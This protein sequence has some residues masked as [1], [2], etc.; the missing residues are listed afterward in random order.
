[1]SVTER[2]KIIG[3]SHIASSS[4]DEIKQTF[5]SYKP[6][7]IAVELDSQRAQPLLQPN[8]EKQKTL[9][10]IRQVGVKGYLFTVIGKKV[11]KKLGK[12]VGV[13][14]GS[15]MKY[16]MQLAKNNNLKLVFADR[17]MKV[18]LKRLFKKIRFKEKLRFV[19]EILAIPYALVR[20]KGMRIPLNKVPSQEQIDTMMRLVKKKYPSVHHVLVDERN[21]YI[22]RQVARKMKSFP[23][24]R[25]LIVVGAGHKKEV[26]RLIPYFFN[27]ME[28]P[29]QKKR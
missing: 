9:S 3:T 29:S 27:R 23:E 15:E 7:A 6:D 5:L 22:A 4:V 10:L 12:M 14:P 1:M 24:K 13:E 25:F 21:T 18:T 26:E 11:Q 2:F 16:A 8:S 17:S 19:G 20:K 28:A